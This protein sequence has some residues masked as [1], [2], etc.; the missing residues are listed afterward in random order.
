MS[1][2]ST[3]STPATE[4]G[5]VTMLHLGESAMAGAMQNLLLLVLPTMTE[6]RQGAHQST[7]RDTLRE[8]MLSGKLDPTAMTDQQLDVVTDVT[9]QKGLL[10]AC[11]LQGKG[12]LSDRQRQQVEG[13]TRKSLEQQI[14]R[15][16][17]V[18]N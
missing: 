14:E 8:Q 13:A 2:F 1:S 15:A 16:K 17:E 3:E 12:R 9:E 4:E 18:W 5:D 6:V 10:L 11:E 7:S